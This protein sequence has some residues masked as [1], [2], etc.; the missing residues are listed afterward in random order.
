MI[1]IEN[2]SPHRVITLVT[3]FL[4]TLIGFSQ[5]NYKEFLRGES[6]ER[7]LELSLEMWN[8]YIRNDIDSLNI[9]VSSSDQ[10]T[11]NL[12][13]FKASMLRNLGSYNVRSGYIPEGLDLLLKARKIFTVSN[14]LVLLSETENEIAN[15]YFVS[16]NYTKASR[17]YL[18]SIQIG[19]KSD[20]NTAGLSAMLSLGKLFCTVGDTIL[21]IKLCAVALSQLLVYDKFETSSD[22]CS[23]LGMIYS[24]LQE[25]E[26]MRAYYTRSLIYS[27]QA[28]SKSNMANALNN[29]A[30]L[31][32]SSN[33]L[34]S[35][36]ILFRKA[37]ELR[38]EFGQR[39]SI[40]ESY[41]NIGGFYLETEQFDSSEVNLNHSLRIAEEVNF[42]PDHLDAL[43][44]LQELY[45]LRD[46]REIELI[47]VELEIDRVSKIIKQNSIID[48]EVYK[49][50]SKFEEKIKELYET[51]PK[52]LLSIVNLGGICLILS[53]LLL[54]RA[55]RR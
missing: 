35:S 21:G 41:F 31:K 16:A 24:E 44:S 34:D 9:R 7:K 6:Q 1:D 46:D 18:S 15:A 5:S 30:I 23:F 8:Y 13:I 51:K 11:V 49:T 32:F 12:L 54:F 47:K 53:I 42:L 3:F 37:L 26:L 27:E 52:P 43:I 2:S 29:Q 20:D 4:W 19:K 55:N 36:L 39:R 38:L 14:E 28:K 25:G 10:S 50:A 40:I 48:I 17:M 33:D 45:I 22:A